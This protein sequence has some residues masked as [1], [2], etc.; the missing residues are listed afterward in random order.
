MEAD[1]NGHM[2]E[3]YTCSTNLW[4]TRYQTVGLYYSLALKNSVI[5]SQHIVRCEILYND[6]ESHHTKNT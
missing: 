2:P 4:W 5:T 3:L 1:D 6:T